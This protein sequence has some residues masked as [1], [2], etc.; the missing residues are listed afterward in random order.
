[1]RGQESH[2]ISGRTASKSEMGHLVCDKCTQQE[3]GSALLHLAITFVSVA[4]P[5]CA[6]VLITSLCLVLRLK[7]FFC[8]CA[9]KW[10][11]S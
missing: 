11:L 1:M 9:T 5:H 2:C 8:V 7:A 10:Y 3:A 4:S 6:V